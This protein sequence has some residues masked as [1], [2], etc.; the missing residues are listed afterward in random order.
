MINELT[1]LIKEAQKGIE[2]NRLHNIP[3]T[4]AS[5]DDYVWDVTNTYR[6]LNELHHMLVE[7]SHEEFMQSEPEKV[8]QSQGQLDA[9]RTY[10]VSL[11][12]T[13]GQKQYTSWDD[14]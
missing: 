7:G 3:Y 10:K 6:E 14:D 13:R 9:Y 1:P 12:E 5:P 4:E 2:W 11:M 8:W